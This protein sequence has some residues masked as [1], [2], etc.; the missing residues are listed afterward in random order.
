MVDKRV[1]FFIDPGNFSLPTYKSESQLDRTKKFLLLPRTFF[2]AK[3][4]L[5]DR[6]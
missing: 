5:A 4:L 2:P 1:A 6:A 3:C